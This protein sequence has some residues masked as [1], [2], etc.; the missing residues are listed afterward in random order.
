MYLNTASVIVKVG[1]DPEKRDASNR[2]P[3]ANWSAGTGHTELHQEDPL[4]LRETGPAPAREIAAS[5]R[6]GEQQTYG[7]PR[8]EDRELGCRLQDLASEPAKTNGIRATSERETPLPCSATATERTTRYDGRKTSGAASLDG[9]PRTPTHELRGSELEYLRV[10]EFAQRV[11][12]AAKTAY[13]WI[14]KGIIGANDGVVTIQGRIF[15][16][17]P[18]YSSRQIRPYVRLAETLQLPKG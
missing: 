4:R 14:H 3:V 9:P 13:N 12:R 16:H 7:S 15:I 11:R 5:A 10:D 2:V 1:R 6:P 8:E 18:T 17:W